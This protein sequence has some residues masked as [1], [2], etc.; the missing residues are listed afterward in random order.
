MHIVISLPASEA[1]PW[2]RLFADALPEARVDRHEPDQ[3][4]NALA[5]QADYVVA[6]YPSKTLFAEQKSPKAVFTVSAGV[7]IRRPL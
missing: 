4:L 1:Q 3:P 2:M 6:A 5:P 7:S